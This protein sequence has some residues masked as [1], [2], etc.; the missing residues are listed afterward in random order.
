[1]YYFTYFFLLVQK[2]PIKFNKTP[3][4]PLGWA[5]LKKTRVFL[6]PEFRTGQQV[7]QC[8]FWSELPEMAV[9]L[10]YLLFYAGG[11]LVTVYCTGV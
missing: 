7:V 5:F 1:L 9:V 3:K 11:S 6:N 2:N 4:T 10:S 8:W